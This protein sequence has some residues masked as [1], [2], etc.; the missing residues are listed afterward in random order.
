MLSN[1]LHLHPVYQDSYLYGFNN[2]EEIHEEVTVNDDLKLTELSDLQ[3]AFLN[4]IYYCNH[5]LD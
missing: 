2:H 4:T 5:Q 1:S 3:V